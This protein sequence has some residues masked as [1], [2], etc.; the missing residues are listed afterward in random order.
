M[1]KQHPGSG[2]VC[3]PVCMPPCV[4]PYVFLWRV[5]LG[6]SPYEGLC[7]TCRTGAGLPLHLLPVLAI[8]SPGLAW[9]VTPLPEA[10][11]RLSSFPQEPTKPRRE[12]YEAGM[13]LGVESWHALGGGKLRLRGV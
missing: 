13:H 1:K 5:I 8:L 7:L 3:V 9:L 6:F 10:S 12:V 2:S 11:L 4:G